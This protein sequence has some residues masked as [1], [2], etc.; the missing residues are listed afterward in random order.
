MQIESRYER[1]RTFHN[2]VFS[3]KSRSSVWKFYSIADVSKRY[4]LECIGA[5]G[6]HDVL[7]IGC[8]R[9]SVAS[10][11]GHDVSFTAIDISDVAVRETA[12]V[13]RA[14]GIAG[15]YLLMNAEETAFADNSFDLVCG[16]GIL[17]HLNLNKAC[18]EIRRI[19]R[20]G[21]SAVFIEPL[22]YNPLINLY[23]KLTP[24]IRSADE[25]PLLNRD[26]DEIRSH[27]TQVDL[28]YFCLLSLAAVPFRKLKIFPAVKS[29]LERVDSFLFHAVPVSGRYAWMVVM[30]M[31]NIKGGAQ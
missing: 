26:M 22:G 8:G 13:A 5:H 21:G 31:S 27:F 3:E 2:W 30:T 23:R 18:A 29:S 7:E 1:E 10:S 16:T 14:N 11:L 12:E 20:P 25:H 24:R 19:S 17:H 15:T 4:Y 6:A 9:G 28:R